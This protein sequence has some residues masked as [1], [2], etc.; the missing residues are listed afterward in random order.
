VE[1]QVFDLLDE[2]LKSI[3]RKFG[4][5]KPTKIQ[6]LAI[7][8]ILRN[9]RGNFLL[10][11]PTGAGKT[12]AAIF[13]ILHI[14]LSKEGIKEKGIL[15]LY[16]TPLRSLN[17][18]IFK[19]LVEIGNALG[20]TIEVRHSDTPKSAKSRQA[21]KP[22]QILITTPESFQSILCGKRIR[23]YLKNVRWVIIDEV[24]ALVDNKRGCQLAVGLERLRELAQRDL[25]I[26]ALSATVQNPR[27]VLEFITGGRGGKI[28]ET[29]EYKKIHLKIDAVKPELSPAPNIFGLGIRVNVAEIARKIVEY[30]D[31]ERGKV[32]VFTN[33]RDLAEL[34]G[35]YMKKYARFPFA[36]HHS[37]LSRELRVGIERDFREG[38]LKCV[39]ATSSL[40]LG[41]DIGEIGLVIQVMSPRRVETALQ[42]IGRSGHRIS[43]ITRGVIIASTIDDLYE[44]LAIARLIKKGI[45]E[46]LKVIDVSYDVL[47]HQIIGIVREKYL[48]RGVYPR[49]SEVYQVIKRAYPFRE[50]S[51]E[52]FKWVLNFLEQRCRLIIRER[53]R[54][55][56][57]K[58]ALSYYF[59]NVSTIP[60][61]LKYDV[62]DIEEGRKIGEVDE[63]F[64]LETEVGDHFLLAGIPREVLE[65]NA[66][67]K[68]VFVSPANIEAVPPKWTGELL[69]VSFEVAQ[70]VGKIRKTWRINFEETLKESYFSPVAKK[71][72]K[73][74]AE[75]YPKDRPIPDDKNIVVEIDEIKGIVIIHSPFGTNINRTLAIL[76]AALLSENPNFPM[77]E[78][79]SDAYRIQFFLYRTFYLREDFLITALEEAFNTLIDYARDLTSLKKFLIEIVRENKLNEVMWYFLQVLK[80]FG[81][82]KSETYLSKTKLARILSEYIDTPVFAEAVHE[83]IFYN[84][85]LK[86]TREMLLKI[87]EGQINIWFVRGLSPLGMA[88]PVTPQVI[89][90]DLDKLVIR[91]YEE[92][93][94][95]KEVLYLCLSC[96]YK[97]IRPV[98]D[99]L[100]KCPRCDS[101][102]IVVS[103]KHEKELPMII[104]KLKKKMKLSA[105]EVEKLI[106]AEQISRFLQTYKELTAITVATRGIGPKQA[107][108]ILKRYAEDR[109]ALIRELRKREAAY[110]RTRVFWQR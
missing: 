52:D 18:D 24:H 84:L 106:L 2:R 45:L 100:L 60:S 78:F 38:N 8:E 66:E 89:V 42:R 40:E 43:L 56:L 79:D 109:S 70:E 3:L 71:W 49:E 73:G 105:K 32:L 83:Y 15:V 55:I 50:L 62:I 57:R 104:D 98:S 23:S 61:V 94:L 28:I 90:R 36:I 13:P 77:T 21:K 68:A 63:K 101:T 16:I 95:R 92:R 12:E 20:I 91:K 30:V 37:S 86:H 54:I 34:L 9:P 17:R 41:I 48:D 58:G 31:K 25:S 65:I 87:D 75:S 19:R 47:A 27:E 103:K 10:I 5:K 4:Y 26:I 44:S 67:K 35:L 76:L 99:V 7:P 51:I 81:L 102:R 11:A 64:V 69:P 39:I 82:V 88:L 107:I 108:E 97:E 74:I 33:T 22:P 6:E 59:E 72:L 93:L 46:P 1:R 14:L 53:G 80:R 85:D 110:F 96:G 29:K